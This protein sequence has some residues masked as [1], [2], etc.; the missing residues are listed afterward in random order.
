MKTNI[1]DKICTL[2]ILAIAIVV[3]DVVFVRWM[4]SGNVQTR[5]RMRYRRISNMSNDCGRVSIYIV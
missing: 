4:V 5:M 3:V 1:N 2:A